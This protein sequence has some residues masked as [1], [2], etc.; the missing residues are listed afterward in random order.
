MLKRS[1]S[2]WCSG[3][4]RPRQDL[5]SA[6]RCLADEG[7]R[8][9][10]YLPTGGAVDVAL[11]GEPVGATWIHARDTTDRRTAV[12]VGDGRRWVAP[13]EGEDWLLYVER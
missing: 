11:L 6:G 1:A 10:V 2:M 12:A 3:R 4:T 13:T 5:V 7:E 8:Y 9:L